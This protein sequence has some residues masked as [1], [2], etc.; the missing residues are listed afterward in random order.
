MTFLFVPFTF[1]EKILG[2]IGRIINFGLAL[3]L[4][5]YSIFI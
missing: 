5:L 1:I 2:I 3:G 4:I